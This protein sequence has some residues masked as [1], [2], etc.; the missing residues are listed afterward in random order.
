MLLE[1]GAWFRAR[2]QFFG[3]NHS[4]E[5]QPKYTQFVF[6][7]G[8][9]ICA[10][11]GQQREDWACHK[12]WALVHFPRKSM[13]AEQGEDS[14]VTL[15]VLAAVDASAH[16]QRFADKVGRAEQKVKAQKAKTVM[17]KRRTYSYA[18]A[19]RSP[20]PRLPPTTP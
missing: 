13:Q 7:C 20:N 5:V 3:N 14:P 9:G 8:Q 16:A 4:L 17:D 18:P 1:V 15:I 11:P 2:Q 19:S 12:P 6:A 10:R